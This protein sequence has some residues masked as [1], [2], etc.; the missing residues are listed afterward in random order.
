MSS[1]AA[2][3]D[4]KPI[5]TRVPVTRTAPPREF[6]NGGLNVVSIPVAANENSRFEVQWFSEFK[7][8]PAQQWLVRQLVVDGNTG[9]WAGHKGTMKSTALLGTPG[10]LILW[11]AIAGIIYV[12]LVRKVRSPFPKDKIGHAGLGAAR[13]GRHENS[14]MTTR[15]ETF[16]QRP[17]RRYPPLRDV[18]HPGT[19]QFSRAHVV[20][21]PANIISE[22]GK[23]VDVDVVR[24][25]RQRI[26]TTREAVTHLGKHAVDRKSEVESRHS[27]GV[28]PAT[29]DLRP[30]ARMRFECPSG[31]VGAIT[32]SSKS[33]AKPPSA[34]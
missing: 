4:R 18:E 20:R 29:V 8:E 31:I 1:L 3:P 11:K 27:L 13:K 2:N 6:E 17:G 33:Q 5:I 9:I 24:A 21:L 22:I 14:G 19:V 10:R 32:R 12:D 16:G 15:P 7:N 28:E 30:F 23:V 34:T 25:H 26:E